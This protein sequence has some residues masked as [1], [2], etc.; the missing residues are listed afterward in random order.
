MTTGPTPAGHR[1]RAGRRPVAGRRPRAAVRRRGASGWPC[2]PSGWSSTSRRHRAAATTGAA[3]WRSRWPPSWSSHAVTGGRAGP[4]A[5]AAGD[6]ARCA[7][8]GV[9]S[10]GVYLWHW[11]V[12]VYVTPERARARRLGRSTPPAWRSRWRWRWRRTVPVERPIRRG[13]LR[14]G[15]GACGSPLALGG[16]VAAIAALVVVATAGVRPTSADVTVV[17]GPAGAAEGYPYRVVPASDAAPGAQDP[18][19]RRQRADLPGAGAGRPRPRPEGAVAA[20][21]RRSSSARCSR[22][23]AVDPLRRDRSIDRCPSVPRRA[24]GGVGRSWSRTST[25]TSSSTTWRPAAGLGRG[26]AWATCGSSDCDPDYDAYL[27]GALAD[28][29]DVLGAGGATVAFGHHAAGRVRGDCTRA[30][31]HRPRRAA[32]PRYRGGGRATGRAPRSLDLEARSSARS[33]RGAG[34][35][36]VRD[37][38]HL[39]DY[40]AELVSQWM[41]PASLDRS[42]RGACADDKA[43]A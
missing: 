18:A 4:V 21:R 3:W 33:R 16:A 32:T 10:Y 19:G 31:S 14:G 2:W 27:R 7:A 35:R 24:A 43:F 36:R 25:P 23:R 15:T 11:P 39:S 1:R 37:P 34:R 17:A 22:P 38:V 5:R 6:G 28:D 9:I 42:T 30:A 40:G 26:A 8:L 13:A 41:V 29:A 12:I 20:Q